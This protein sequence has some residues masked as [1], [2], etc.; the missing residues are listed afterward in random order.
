VTTKVLTEKE[1]SAPAHNDPMT[2]PPLRITG[3]AEADRLLTEDD[4]ALLVAMLLD[5]QFPMER[6]FAGP[7]ILSQRMGQDFDLKVIASY[8]PAA[9]AALFARPPAIHRYHGSMA[10][11]VQ[12]LARYVIEHY[13]GRAENVWTGAA[14]AQEVLGR[15]RA[16][17][18]FGEQKAKIF[19]ALLGKQRGVRPDGWREAAGVY[20]EEDSFR[21]VADVVGEES[22]AN[23]RA[24]KQ[25]ARRAAKA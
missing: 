17:P 22:L 8:D 3:D 21:S 11:R 2:K 24:F 12:E 6:A 14:S 4:N 9:L 5:Q 25:A 1:A 18:G 20:G 13:G 19:V 23:V 7:Y 16:L 10:A 15:L